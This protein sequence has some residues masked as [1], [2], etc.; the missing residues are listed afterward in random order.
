MSPCGR[1]RTSAP[2]LRLRTATAEH[3]PRIAGEQQQQQREEH[4]GARERQLTQ[5]LAGCS[6]GLGEIVG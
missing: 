1:P 3:L 6:R 2:P 4:L 5:G